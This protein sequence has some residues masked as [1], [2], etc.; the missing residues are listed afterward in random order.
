MKTRYNNWLNSAMGIKT[1]K[2]NGGLILQLLI[3]NLLFFSAQA[4]GA[5]FYKCKT[6]NGQITFSDKPCPKKSQTT[7]KG[8]LNSFRISGTVGNEEYTD[9]QNSYDANSVFAF[10]AKFTN[11]LHSL[12]PLRMSITQYYME[13]GK[14]PENMEAL[15]FDRQAMKSSQIDGV[16][17]KKDGKITAVLNTKLGENK[18]IVL[19]PKPAMSETQIDWQCWS[20]FPRTLLGGGELEICGSRNI[21]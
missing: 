1:M 12:S 3:I 13:R 19:D 10:R 2:D 21:F 9:N 18:F 16:R 11:I 15:G 20:N 7:K 4:V 17:I 14:W 6:S 5:N 8:K